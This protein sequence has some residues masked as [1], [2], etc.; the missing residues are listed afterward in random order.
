[1][2]VGKENEDKDKKISQELKT[3]DKLEALF[4]GLNN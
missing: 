3:K 1:M 4:K 2:T